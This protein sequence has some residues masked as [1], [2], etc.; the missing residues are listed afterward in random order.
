V[1]TVWHDFCICLGGGTVQPPVR[2]LTSADRCCQQIN[3]REEIGAQHCDIEMDS[4]QKTTGSV[5]AA[6]CTIES[7]AVQD[8]LAKNRTPI[9]LRLVAENVAEFAETTTQTQKDPSFE[10]ACKAGCNWCCYQSVRVTPP[11]VFRIVEFIRSMPD[12]DREEL[13]SRL[14]HL[15]KLTR[16]ISQKKRAKLRLACAFLKDGLCSIYSVRPLA[17]AEFTSV[18]A[19]DCERGFRKGFHKAH[20]T[21][22]MARIMVYKGAERG[23][24]LGLRK[25]LPNADTSVLELTAAVAAALGSPDSATAWLEGKPVFK[26]ARSTSR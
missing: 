11:E 23:L 24:L 16:G 3:D 18:N 15:R 8:M 26:D 22:E 6:V 25:A 19:K 2:S 7:D 14:R 4:E 1:E 9:G 20:V 21:H 10:L 5:W 12:T 17:C 13:E